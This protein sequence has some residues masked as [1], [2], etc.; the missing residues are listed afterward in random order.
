MRV[1]SLERLCD[2]LIISDSSEFPLFGNERSWQP[3]VLV[4]NS[5]KILALHTTLYCDING[6]AH[7]FYPY[8]FVGSVK[9]YPVPGWVY[10]YTIIVFQFTGEIFFL[11][12]VGV[13]SN[14]PRSVTQHWN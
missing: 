13:Y 3:E 11:L 7:L 9:I 4:F 14:Q 10:V 12:T 5:V 8:L 1:T 2:C 6:E